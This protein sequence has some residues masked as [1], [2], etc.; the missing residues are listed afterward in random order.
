MKTY[1][2]EYYIAPNKTEL[3]YIKADSEEIAL[4][5][6]RAKYGNK[7]IHHICDFTWSAS[8]LEEKMA[9]GDYE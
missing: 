6:F 3:V 5:R 7:R 4:S 8:M 1:E 2:I 9:K